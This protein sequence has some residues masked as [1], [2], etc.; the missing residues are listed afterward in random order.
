VNKK[1]STIDWDEHELTIIKNDNIL[2]HSLK[3]PNTV[4]CSIKFINTN[5]IC[6]VTGDFGNWIFCREF[7]PSK[8][9]G[10]SDYY[11][12]EKLEIYSVQ[13]GLEFN[14]SE[15]RKTIEAGINGGLVEYGHE[16]ENLE[17]VTEYYKELLGYTDL[18]EWEYVSYA[19]NNQPDFMDAESVPFEET[20]KPRLKI[21]FDAFEEICNRFD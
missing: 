21:V 6:A 4:C 17:K 9:G 8:D 7:H 3:K 2:I 18:Q 12:C 10:V 1:R 19:Y 15:T 20:I 14:S 11:W 5:D 16:G 13:K